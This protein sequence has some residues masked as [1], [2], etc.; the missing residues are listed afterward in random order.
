MEK[1]SFEAK[2]LLSSAEMFDIKAGEKQSAMM[3]QGCDLCTSCLACTLCTACVSE[4]LD[5]ITLPKL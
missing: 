2:D 5:V 3:D 4:A 1:Y